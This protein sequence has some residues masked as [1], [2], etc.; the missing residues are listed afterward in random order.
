MG[1]PRCGKENQDHYK[2]CLGCG[3]EL[4]RTSAKKDAARGLAGGEPATD[5]ATKVDPG[6]FD[7]NMQ[8]A[9][10]QQG[11]VATTG[12]PRGT[13]AKPMTASPALS[14]AMGSL[15][16]PLGVAPPRSLQAG[17]PVHRCPA[18]SNPV[19]ADFKFCGTCGHRIGGA[20]PAAASVAAP[21]AAPAPAAPPAAAPAAALASANAQPAGQARGKLVLIN[22]DG[23]EGAAFPLHDGATAIGRT[24][25][26]LFAGDAYLSPLHATFV[27]KGDGCLVR[28]E[29]SL[30]GVYVKL[31]RD[32]PARLSHGDVFRIGQEII[33]FEQIPAAEPVD[34]VEIMGSQNP[35][36]LGRICLIIG[37]ESIGHAHTVAPDGIYVGRERGDVIFPED[38][39]VSGLHCRIHRDGTAVA[40]TDIGSSNGTFLRV[41]GERK[42]VS[43]E[44]VL[45]GQQLFRLQY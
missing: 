3:A 5:Q 21:A 17:P 13:A 35:G 32:R 30:N 20:A 12:V 34:G 45:M 29:Q 36:Y 33:R 28:D 11:D 16:A 26:R 14:P 39:Y 1:C 38:G 18:C 25:G 7:R 44:L 15:P 9:A 24:T 40:L 23:S 37:R 10:T 22:P 4:P 43:G 19:P 8:F 2:F 6:R 42:L 31:A 27:L 41:R